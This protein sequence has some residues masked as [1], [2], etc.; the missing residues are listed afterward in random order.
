M[1]RGARG[2]A[3]SS[4]RLASVLAALVR[5]TPELS[6]AWVTLHSL[7]VGGA[8]ALQEAGAP[9]PVLQMA[10]RWRSDAY[11]AYL[12]FSRTSAVE[13]SRKMSGSGLQ[14]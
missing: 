12:R 6:A 2:G 7:R 13:W 4:E 9:E 11:K 10:G 3:L 14:C 5:A 8:V 1:F